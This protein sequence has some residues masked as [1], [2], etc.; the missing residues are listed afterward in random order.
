MI[1]VPIAICAFFFFG[2]LT[3][4]KNNPFAPSVLTSALWLGTLLL[5]LTVDHHLPP[6]S[7]YFFIVLSCWIFFQNVSSLC[8]QS[9]TYRQHH[10]NEPSKIMRNV[11]LILSIITFPSLLQFAHTAVVGG[12]TG[13][14][15]L[16]LRLAA[17]GKGSGF[18]ETY[19][20]WQTLIWPI[21]YMLELL[22]FKK[23]SWWR[24]GIALFVYG[25]FGVLT[26]SKMVFLSIFIY[27]GCILFFK[28]IIRLKHVA[29]AFLLLLM[30]F[31]SL[32]M[33]RHSSQLTSVVSSFLGTYLLGNMSAFDTL[34]PCTADYF[35]QNTFRVF[36]AIAY[37]IGLSG[38][39]PVDAI[40]PWIE[41]PLITNTY[42]GMYPFFV[43]FGIPGV[44][45]FAVVL[46]AVYG[47]IFKKAQYGSNFSI[48]VYAVFAH[49]I[50][51]QYVAD[52]IFTNTAGY[53]KMLFLLLVAFYV[54]KHNLLV[55]K[56]KVVLT[57]DMVKS[58]FKF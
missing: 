29:F 46:G 26:M 5:F 1:F 9:V 50:V 25:M 6:L 51:V 42:T 12:C 52:M 15:A 39:E 13:N 54:N 11:F 38:T 40:L 45:I 3:C 37:K 33:V 43:D 30:V 58:M 48:L 21:S 17:L 7:N 31:A 27:S 41:K 53:L 22:C 8:T 14:W 55:C 23:K 56:E 34:S 57:M 20:G 4:S 10:Y 28:R 2:G 47:W 19:G 35:G 18:K 44:I 36:Y 24:L 49:M 16:D 32:Q